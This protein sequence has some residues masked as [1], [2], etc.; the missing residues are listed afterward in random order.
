MLVK[1]A[2]QGYLICRALAPGFWVEK[3]G[4]LIGWFDTIE[5]AKA[6]IDGLLD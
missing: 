5:L 1:Q 3:D 2:Y 6:G 4:F